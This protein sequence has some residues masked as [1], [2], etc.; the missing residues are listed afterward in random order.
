MLTT[1]IIMHSTWKLCA[2]LFSPTRSERA[3]LALSSQVN[4]QFN[5]FSLH[6]RMQVCI[7][8]VCMHRIYIYINH[9]FSRLASRLMAGWLAV[10]AGSADRGAQGGRGLRS[11]V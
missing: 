1:Y 8:V 5:I 3:R 6:I 9:T 7:H 2:P 11:E 4:R 10:V